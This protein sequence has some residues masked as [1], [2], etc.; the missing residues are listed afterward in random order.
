MNKAQ[1]KIYMMPCILTCLDGILGV[2]LLEKNPHSLLGCS[3][4]IAKYQQVHLLEKLEQRDYK[5]S[6][7]RLGSK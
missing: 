7:K 3:L 1:Q 4:V 2:A 6:E 5:T